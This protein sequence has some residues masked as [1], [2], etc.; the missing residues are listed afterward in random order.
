MTDGTTS[1]V[2]NIIVLRGVSVQDK[3]TRDTN[4]RMLHFGTERILNDTQ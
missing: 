1:A 2:G 3:V 4:L